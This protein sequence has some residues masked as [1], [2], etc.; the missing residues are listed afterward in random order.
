MG[1]STFVE[2]KAKN[3]DVID[4][5]LTKWSAVFFGILIGAYF[6]GAVLKYWVIFLLFTILLAIRPA[7]RAL[8]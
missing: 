5:G 8:K 1:F 4:L 2:K 7:Y 3:L 6:A